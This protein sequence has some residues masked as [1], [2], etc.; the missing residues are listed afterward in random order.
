MEC[1]KPEKLKHPLSVGDLYEADATLA[2]Q[3][4]ECALR[5]KQWIEWEASK[6][7]EQ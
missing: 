1:P 5:L 4:L 7:E 6:P 2:R 3:Y